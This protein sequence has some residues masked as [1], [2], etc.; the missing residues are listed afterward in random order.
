MRVSNSELCLITQ[1]FAIL[2]A[3]G[4]TIEQAL[5]ALIEQI[6]KQSLREILASVRAGVNEGETL[7]KA[8]ERYHTVFPPLYRAIVEAGE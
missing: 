4:L 6:A 7:A 3:A 1:P 2:L 8:I 5:S